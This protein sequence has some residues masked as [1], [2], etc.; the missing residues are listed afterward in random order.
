MLS[1]FCGHHA[2]RDD[3]PAVAMAA[4]PKCHHAERDDFEMRL[5]PVPPIVR[6]MRKGRRESTMITFRIKTDVQNDRRVIVTLPPEV[7]IG[8][9]ELVVTIDS[10]TANG[11]NSP[12]SNQT[13]VV[14]NKSEF[15]S[16]LEFLESL[17][18][19]PRAFKTWEEYE[20]H[21]HDEKDAWGR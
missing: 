6:I 16:A 11:E 17:P 12:R 5:S 18:S 4:P 9:A 13:E 14:A 10:L 1:P 7:P 3:I 15:G 8:P 21:L 19:G 2:P 20:R